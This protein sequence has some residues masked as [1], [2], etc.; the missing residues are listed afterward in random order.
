MLQMTYSNADDTR[1]ITQS[2]NHHRT[3]T[4]R[5]NGCE[6]HQIEFVFDLANDGTATEVVH[7]P[8]FRVRCSAPVVRFDT[9]SQ[10]TFRRSTAVAAGG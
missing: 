10:A 6:S 4:A 8:Q 9:R 2:T 1:E 7:S 5:D 3:V